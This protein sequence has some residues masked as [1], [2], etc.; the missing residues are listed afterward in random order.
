MATAPKKPMIVEASA[1]S[2]AIETFPPA[3]AEMKKAVEAAPAIVTEMQEKMRKAVEKSVVDAREAYAKAKT[4]AEQATGALETSLAAAKTG[5]A[6]INTK[7]LQAMRSNVEA[8][9]DFAHALVGVKSVSDFVALQSEFT[10]K[11][12]ETFTGQT[13]ELSALA[14]KVANDS[15]API[16]DQVAKSLKIAV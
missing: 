4:A 1:P 9:F 3:A 11:Q 14:Q 16:K 5:L 6:E 15:T 7:A 8:N 12:V 13:K 2:A 10:R